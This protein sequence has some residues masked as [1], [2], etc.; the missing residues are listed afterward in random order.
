[1][2]SEP[3]SW[4]DCRE[5]RFK[6]EARD[7]DK[8]IGAPSYRQRLNSAQMAALLSL[9]TPMAMRRCGHL[10]LGTCKIRGG[11]LRQL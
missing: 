4:I 6:V 11:R 1:V 3:A 7:D 9:R 5:L 8:K 10:E 2:T